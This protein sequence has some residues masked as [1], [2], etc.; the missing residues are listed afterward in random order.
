MFLITFYS[1]L[2]HGWAHIRSAIDGLEAVKRAAKLL[3]INHEYEFVSVKS[4]PLN[5]E[6]K[7]YLR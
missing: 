4:V 2:T 5:Y 6:S 7:R 1:P 3:P